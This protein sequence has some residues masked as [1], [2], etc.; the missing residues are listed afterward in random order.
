MPQNPAGGEKTEPA[1]P[2][3]REEARRRGQVARSVDLTSSI[4]L[5]VALFGLLFLGPT[6]FTELLDLLRSSFSA[7]ATTSLTQADVPILFGSILMRL[8]RFF[9]PFFAVL[10]FAALGL[11]VLQVGFFATAEP[12]EPKPERID[13]IA[14]FR[15][16]FSMRSF[17]EFLK[18]I[19]KLGLIAYIAY[20][21]VRGSMTQFL[22]ASQQEPIQVVTLISAVGFQVLFRCALALLVIG[23]LDYAFQRYQFEQDIQMTKEEVRQETK[24]FEGDPQV[25]ARI[26]RVRRQM[27]TQRMMAEVPTADVVVTNPTFIA[28]ALR[29]D[30]ATMAAPT[31]VA[32]GARLAAERIR[33]M[34]TAHG[35]PIVQNAPLAQTLY[36]AVEVNHGV[37]ST[38]YRAVAELL[39]FVYQINQE[40]RS[41]WASLQP[42]GA[43]P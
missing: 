10:I 41:K 27:A 39:A 24:D 43:A 2:R 42:Q 8:S 37:P 36:K 25:R 17:V 4:V 13:P 28:V 30:V 32:K 16:M 29:Y 31:V 40:S 23:V 38:L 26:R 21:T 34:A 5:I 22:L 18:S 7:S 11:N 19:M 6:M 9:V 33:E 35:V 14:G 15:R 1:T 20:V 12:L 3:R